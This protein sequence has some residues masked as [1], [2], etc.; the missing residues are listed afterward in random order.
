MSG[1]SHNY[2]SYDIEE[3]LVG[4]MFDP[5]LD[6]LMKDVAD[7]VHDLEWWQS[8]DTIEEVYRETVA[9]FKRKWLTKDGYSE[10]VKR[11]IAE[12]MQ[13]NINFLAGLKEE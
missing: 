9:K 4:K 6:E 7:L 8:S 13:D 11:I 3:L 12:R 10:E 5:V 1:G 2:I